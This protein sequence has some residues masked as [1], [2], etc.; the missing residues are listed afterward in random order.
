VLLGWTSRAVQH[1]SYADGVAH[2]G[3]ARAAL[4]TARQW[5]SRAHKPIARRD[6]PV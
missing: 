5:L 1:L 2:G 4:D 3:C 6:V